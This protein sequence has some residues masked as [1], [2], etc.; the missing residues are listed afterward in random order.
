MVEKSNASR[1][2]YAK[3]MGTPMGKQMAPALS[4]NDVL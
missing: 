1:A 3:M 4:F 2:D